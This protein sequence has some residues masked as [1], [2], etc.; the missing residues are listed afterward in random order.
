LGEKDVEAFCDSILSG[1]PIGGILLWTPGPKADLEAIS[2][3][4][5][6][7]ISRAEKVNQSYQ[8]SL[9]LDG[10]N[11]LSTLAWMMLKNHNEMAN[12]DMCSEQER[13]VW[14][15]PERKLMLDGNTKSIR[16]VSHQEA[17]QGLKLPAW[18]VLLPAKDSNPE[19]RRRWSAWEDAGFS[20]SDINNFFKWYDETCNAFRSARLTSTQLIDATTEEARHAFSRICR[21]G[22]PMSQEDFDQAI[23]WSR[24]LEED[25][26]RPRLVG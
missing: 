23:G 21:V 4:R 24:D 18:T 22:V 14:L 15:N 17:A 6:G 26:Q 13:L 16:F 1:F 20:D 3:G 9:L 11:R 7:P 8:Y 25:T 5:I 19:L 12:L 10:Q 2:K